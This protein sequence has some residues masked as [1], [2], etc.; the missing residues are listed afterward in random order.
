MQTHQC[1]GDCEVAEYLRNLTRLRLRLRL[2][3]TLAVK[4]WCR[5]CGMPALIEVV[6][7]YQVALKN[8]E[9]LHEQPMVHKHIHAERGGWGV[10]WR[11]DDVLWT[12]FP[13]VHKAAVWPAPPWYDNYE[14]DDQAVMVVNAADRTTVAEAQDVE[15][16]MLERWINRNPRTRE[17][18]EGLAEEVLDD[19]ELDS[20]FE[21]LGL[22]GPF[23]VV[24]ERESGQQ[25]SMMFQNHPRFYFGFDPNRLI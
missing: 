7:D 1:R 19:R 5:V 22:K 14:A 21:L 13:D 12:V 16:R 8:F 2:P 25:G 23:A 9:A 6:N 4:T 3:R 11:L 24:R 10:H 20:R 18:L 15:I 17:Q